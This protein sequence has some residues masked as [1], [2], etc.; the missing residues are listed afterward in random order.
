MSTVAAETSPSDPIPSFDNLLL[1]CP[2]EGIVVLSSYQGSHEFLVPKLY[3]IH[4]S[5]ILREEILLPPSP[6]PGVSANAAQSG[7]DESTDSDTANAHRVVQLPV[8]GTILISLLSYILPVPPILPSTAEQIMELLSVAQMYKMDVVLTHLRNH[9]AQRQPPLIC[10]ETAFS[11]YA[12][13]QKYGLRTEALQ[14]ARCTLTF[15]SLTFQDLA[16]ED[17]LR[18]M[19]GAFLHELWK[20][21]RRFWSILSSEIYDFK[22]SRVGQ[23]GIAKDSTCESLTD[24]G[25]PYWLD[26]YLSRQGSARIHNLLDFTAFHSEYVDHC[27]RPYP[28]IHDGGCLCCSEEVSDE[29]LDEFWEA[30]KAVVQGSMTKVRFLPIAASVDRTELGWCTG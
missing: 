6:R 28:K 8:N 10:K 21:H 5:P 14:A 15:S 23:L 24:S 13:A 19:P 17:K 20:Y 29:D 9:I 25:I 11:V 16:E 4:S 12:L 3:I 30:L 18:L 2:E 7:V 22:A 27:E 1:D 26:G